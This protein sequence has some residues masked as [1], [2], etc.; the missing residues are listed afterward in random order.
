MSDIPR[1]QHPLFPQENVDFGFLLPI[2]ELQVYSIAI[3]KFEMLFKIEGQIR[4]DRHA[5]GGTPVFFSKQPRSP[6][7]CKIFPE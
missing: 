5:L 1:L 4:L 6:V 7:F 3:Y 2:L